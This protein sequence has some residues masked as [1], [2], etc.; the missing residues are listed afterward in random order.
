MD[1]NSF[2]GATFDALIDK[3]IKVSRTADVKKY[4]DLVG[5]LKSIEQIVS[6]MNSLKAKFLVK[7]I[8]F[9]KNDP[10]VIEFLKSVI[11]SIS[12]SDNF[13]IR[14]ENGAHSKIGKLITK[15]CYREKKRSKRRKSSLEQ[16]YEETTN[17]YEPVRDDDEESKKKESSA[18][19]EGNEED[20]EEEEEDFDS[21]NYDDLTLSDNPIKREY[22]LRASAPRPAPYSRQSPQR[23]YCLMT[24]NEFRLAGAFTE[25][26]MFF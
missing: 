16:H 11:R 3:T 20:E 2:L 6:Q 22:I 25:D 17:R 18:F 26:T 15:V 5:Y 21:S 7:K 1:L 24:S 23:M 4:I 10:E 13:E 19:D 14:I 8:A 9:K 12:T